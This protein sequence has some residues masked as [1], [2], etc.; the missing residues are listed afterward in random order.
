M[1]RWQLYMWGIG[2]EPQK[3]FRNENNVNQYVGSIKTLQTARRNREISGL[4]QE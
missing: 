1:V 4:M 2:S 3:F